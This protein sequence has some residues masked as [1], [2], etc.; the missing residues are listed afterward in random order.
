MS[1]DEVNDL[2]DLIGREH[3]LNAQRHAEVLGRLDTI[4]RLL[5]QALRGAAPNGDQA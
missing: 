1:E 2:Y 5:R 4:E 3:V